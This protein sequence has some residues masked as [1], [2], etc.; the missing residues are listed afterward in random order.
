MNL[1]TSPRARLLAPLLLVALLSTAASGLQWD[2]AAERVDDGGFVASAVAVALGPDGTGGG[3][4]V[5][6]NVGLMARIYDGG[7]GPEVMVATGTDSV[8]SPVMAATDDGR[9]LLVWKHDTGD[10][11]NVRYATYNGAWSTAA[12]LH[13]PAVGSA[14]GLLSL[15]VAGSHVAVAWIVDD[16]PAPIH[17]ALWN[18]AT[19]DVQ[20][21]GT[22]EA[23]SPDVA[24]D[25]D[26]TAWLVWQEREAGSTTDV[27]TYSTR[28]AG[29]SWSTATSVD[30]GPQDVGAAQ[31]AARGGHAHLLVQQRLD[32]PGNRLVS[33]ASDGADWEAPRTLATYSIT[34]GLD[35]D[36]GAAPDGSAIAA[37][38]RPIDGDIQ[39]RVVVARLD[40]TSWTIHTPSTDGLRHQQ[41]DLTVDRYG[42]AMVAWTS[43]QATIWALDF[44]AG[45]GWQAP[46]ETPGMPSGTNTRPNAALSPDGQGLV[47]WRRVD[48]NN[49]FDQSQYRGY[50]NALASDRPGPALSLA[51]PGDLTNQAPVLLQGTVTPG[52]VL[53]ADGAPLAVDPADG[54]FALSLDLADGEHT[55]QLEATNGGGTESLTKSFTVDTVAPSL[56][57]TAPL[58]GTETTEIIATV[59]GTAEPG[60]QVTVD[61]RDASPDGAGVFSLVVSLHQG[62]N[63]IDVV[64]T[65]AAGNEAT[66]SVTVTTTSPSAP[67]PEDDDEP[68]DGDGTGDG[69]GDGGQGGDGSGNG[70]PAIPDG[71]DRDEDVP[72][73]H[74]PNPG[75]DDD[76]KDSPLP[77]GAVI[78]AL[79]AA[80]AMVACRRF[81]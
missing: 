33:L 35:G 9:L 39:P 53:T 12:T 68:T 11:Y 22:S 6:N 38:V 50:A 18:G 41:P 21:I 4:W 3:A 76:G 43:G 26:G 74:D 30:L 10:H 81:R 14:N 25:T 80:V 48:A 57:V 31:I 32:E 27:V 46:V 77:F 62:E 75:G 67:P 73:V 37:W 64:A 58:D 29:G 52:T 71:R 47:T 55:V 59:E 34:A 79:L 2:G 40:G 16:A 42:N 66:T 17:V 36:I 65:D 28:P 49:L 23:S 56:E 78:I 1:G 19:W 5:K 63:V 24:I 8:S 15:D 70:D 60:A 61:G 44:V 20:S 7:W 69:T 13:D 45:D 72:V 54:S 51:G